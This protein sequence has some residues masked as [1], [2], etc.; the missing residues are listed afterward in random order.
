MNLNKP[1]FFKKNR[2]RRIYT[3]GSQFASF[4]G[5]DSTEG[6]FP[7]EW[8]CSYVK[9]LNEGSDIPDEGISITEDGEKFDEL[10]KNHTTEMLGEGRTELGILT[11]ILD[12]SIRL[13]VQCHPDKEFSRKHFNSEYGKTES[14]IILGAGEDACIYFGFNK[15]YTKEEFRAAFDKDE[16]VLVSMLNKIPVNVGDVF[17]IPGKAIH[18]IGKNCLLLEVQEPTDFTIQP[19]NTCGDYVLSDNEKYL[20]LDPDIAFD[21]FDMELDSLEK[22]L[23]AAKCEPVKVGNVEKL[24]THEKTPCFAVNRYNIKGEKV[25][26]PC[27][28]VY[29]VTDGTGKVICDDFVR[30]VRKGDYFFAPAVIDGKLFAEGDMKIIQCDLPLNN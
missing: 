3:G 19:E 12:S 13:P 8:V 15:R 29:V 2:V 1:L 21:C 27:P 23:K 5:D 28:S 9:A 25:S 6:F 30:D 10:L 7:E 18:A 11:K 24:I 14:W 4:F 22:T 16:S 17:L 20:G 26:L